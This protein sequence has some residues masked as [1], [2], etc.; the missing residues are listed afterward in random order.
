MH[1]ECDAIRDL[2]FDYR[3]G[4]LPEVERRR[5]DDHLDSCASCVDHFSRI[6][7][8]LEAPTA[9][10]EEAAAGIDPDALFARITAQ[11]DAESS[12]SNTL[13]LSEKSSV[14]QR[15]SALASESTLNIDVNAL[16]SAPTAASPPDTAAEWGT[17]TPANLDSSW[18]PR[19]RNVWWVAAIA[20]VFAGALATGVWRA[21]QPAPPDFDLPV[22]ADNSRIELP[23]LSAPAPTVELRG[24][25]DALWHLSDEEGSPRV[26]T[27]D[28]GAVLVE[29]LPD[30]GRDLTVHAPDR[31][32]VVVGTVF[33]VDTTGDSTEVGVLTGAVEIAGERVTDGGMHDGHGTRPMSGEER[34]RWSGHV[35]VAMHEVRLEA[36]TVRADR[37]ELPPAGP[38]TGEVTIAAAQIR[39]ASEHASPP[40]REER[41]RPSRDRSVRSEPA[42]VAPPVTLREQAERAMAEQRWAD[43]TDAYERLIRNGSVSSGA[44]LDLARLYLRRLDEPARAVPHLRAFVERNP[45]D[46]VAESARRELCRILEA[47]GEEEPLCSR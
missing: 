14:T 25:A 42:P 37:I 5:V 11:I 39:P 46:P 2:S 45:T 23:N 47:S 12:P 22:L 4:E 35:D 7:T 41:E 1:N 36:A 29:Y 26:L 15:F 33:F 32:F 44:R 9:L 10:A 8:L 34:A 38:P 43:A 6:A 13:V 24:T 17:D 3:S 31:T 18:S 30:D 27:V 16:P 20:A 40:S 21:A 19:S 28:A